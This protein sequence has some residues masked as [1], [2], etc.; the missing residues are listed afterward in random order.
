MCVIASS[1]LMHYKKR[2]KVIIEAIIVIEKN[3]ENEIEI[4]I[5]KISILINHS[6]NR[7]IAVKSSA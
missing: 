3:L 7:Q 2:F 5:K 6:R 4:E 1:L